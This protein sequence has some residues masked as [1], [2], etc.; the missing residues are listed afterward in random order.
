M[1]QAPAKK[2]DIDASGKTI[3]RVAAEAARALMGKAHADY[4]PHIPSIVVVTVSNAGKIRVTE[5][6]RLQKTY[7]DYS[8]HPGGLKV[9]SLSSLIGRRGKSAAVRR[10]IE[11]MLPRNKLR[12]GRLKR[13]TITE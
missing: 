6:K 10:A 3:G 1:T 8:G 13:L 2:Y 5:K 12:P 7:T 11:R 4:T 9:E